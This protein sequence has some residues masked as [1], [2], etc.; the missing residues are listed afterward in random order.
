MHPRELSV[1]AGTISITSTDT[2]KA[3][4][5]VFPSVAGFAANAIAGRI[6]AASTANALYATEGGNVLFKVC[7][8]TICFLAAATLFEH[9]IIEL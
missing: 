5:D 8:E 1:Q 3:V 4:V 2:T 7:T 6:A 9:H